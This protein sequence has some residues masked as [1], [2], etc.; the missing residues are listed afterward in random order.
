MTESYRGKFIVLDGGDGC[1]K[2]TQAKLLGQWLEGQGI[3]AVGYRDPGTT[4][5]G[6]R[7]REILLDRAH[8]KM[9][10][11]TEVLLYMA[12]RAQLWEEFIGQDLQNGACVVMDRWVSSTCAYQGYAGGFGMDKVVRIAETALE[13]VWPDLTVVLDVDEATAAERL[14][15]TGQAADRMEAKGGGYHGRVREGFVRLAEQYEQVVRI[16]AGGD[17]QSVHREIVRIIQERIGR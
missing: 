1:G 2:S 10:D 12:A 9:A 17:V 15:M 14:R 3:H 5:I 8:E 6:E 13:R 16:D 11:N 7:V 4:V